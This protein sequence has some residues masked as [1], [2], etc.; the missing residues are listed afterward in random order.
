MLPEWLFRCLFSCLFLFCY[1]HSLPVARLAKLKFC[2]VLREAF[3]VARRAVGGYFHG[4]AGKAGLC[5]H[6]GEMVG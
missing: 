1:D 2:T 5:Q 3:T 4:F 6:G